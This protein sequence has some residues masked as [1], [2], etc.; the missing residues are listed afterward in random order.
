MSFELWGINSIP[1]FE[2]PANIAGYA[3]I[4]LYAV[5]LIAALASS[6]GDFLRLKPGQWILFIGLIIAG[7]LLITVL[8]IRF[9][10]TVAPPGV[11]REPV[12]PTLSLLGYTP[13]V[14]AAGL[15]GSGPAILV[16]LVS[17]LARA[18]W[19][20]FEITTLLET[21]LAA[22]TLS[23]CIRQGYRGWLPRL[24]RFPP[25]A[26]LVTALA[27]WLLSFLSY[28]ANS[29]TLGLNGIDFITAEWL[30]G[31]LPLLGELLTG[32]VI[33]TLGLLAFPNVW[34]P[35]TG[36]FPP[37]YS[38]S[39]NR[40]LLF[41]LLPLSF[42]GLLTLIWANSRIAVQVATSLLVDQMGR[43][44]Q[45]AANT[46]PYF[47][48]TGQSIL[49]SLS[50]DPHIQN[51]DPLELDAWLSDQIRAIAF[52]RELAFFDLDG[53]LMGAYPQQQG[54][55]NELLTFEEQTAFALGV[56][57]TI[58]IYPGDPLE[59]SVQVSF[60]VPVINSQSGA[61]IGVLVGRADIENNPLLK[62]AIDE[63]QSLSTN[64]GQGFI[65]DDQSNIIFHPDRTQLI[66]S[67]LPADQPDETFTTN[68]AD[69]LAY[70]DRAPGNTRQLVYVLPVTGFPW[71][72]VVMVP[73]ETVLAQ[74]TRIVTPLV[75]ILII[76]GVIGAGLVFWV[77]SQITRPLET[78]AKATA[79]ITQGEFSKPVQISGED[80]VGRLGI[81]FEKMRERLRAR[82]EEL[83]LLL[84][85]SQGIAGSLNVGQ[86]L[87]E[88]LEGALASTKSDGVRLIIHNRDGAP[89]SSLSAGPLSQPM[90]ALDHDVLRLTEHED[91]PVVLENLARA[92]AVIDVSKVGSQI[93]ALIALP[94][95]QESQFLG[96]LWVGFS[97][98]HAFGESE[99]NFLTTLAGQAAVAISNANLYEASEGGRQ[100]LQAILAS[101]PD[102]V[103]VIDRRERV[104][105]LNPAAESI[106][107]VKGAAAM[108]K[109][110]AEVINRAELID[111][112][113]SPQLGTPRQIPL[114][115]GR[116]LFASASPIMA[117]D[118]N[119]L[120]QVMVLRDVTYFKQL[121]ELKSEFVATV[122][123]DLRVPLTFMRGY[124]TM[125]PMVGQLNPKQ[126][127]FAEKIVVGIEQ[128]SELIEDLLDLNRIE[129]GVGLVRETCQINELINSAVSNFRNN[130]ANKNMALTLQL[131][132]DLPAI[133][134]DKTLLRQA[135]SNLVD[136]AVKY[137]PAGGRVKISSDLRDM[138]VVVSV[139]DTG[140]GIAPT[141]Q[142]RLFEKFFRVKQ[143][144]TIGIKGSGLGLAIVKSI[145]ERHGGRLWV[146]SRL[147][148]GSSFYIALPI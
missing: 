38:S 118:G 60:I 123:H 48:Q 55:A 57:Q 2:F 90:A 12:G 17:G 52:F 71:S 133:S 51:P 146:E 22:A 78:L 135:I 148:Q 19:E 131:A 145:V 114:D 96:A 147:G 45:S 32:G 102:A 116:T 68:I 15:L 29:T 49:N 119:R 144:D 86:S 18:G 46:V 112:I 20:T 80:E 5:L 42:L 94:L 8:R 41:T 140:I 69:G 120:G 125:L 108:N 72:V 82:L 70:R 24:L 77:T 141:D 128:M 37:P 50:I 26:S 84:R 124:A 134:G 106:F 31:A 6:F 63:L 25:V 92:R 67:W 89:P 81:A 129:A 109:P 61:Q 85:I 113:R 54:T 28:L 73:N 101:S 76:I 64:G 103:V 3:V 121:D 74:A 23:W 143:R 30:N 79:S 40:R 35:R 65:L 62:P 58:T 66:Q 11:P 53:S 7:P 100:Q 36:R 14:L 111:L 43:D 130:A 56:P 110:L 88:L 99:L 137:T 83:N 98:T 59:D 10:G 13:I 142:A 47:A 9:P 139:Q 122:S 34:A 136:N 95:R 4:G 97:Q 39:L 126:G 127:E 27:I 104:L 75:A 105:L 21:A 107:G 87:P 16:G 93:Q 132:D 138:N 117:D 1:F 33:G 115:D 91:R 44:A